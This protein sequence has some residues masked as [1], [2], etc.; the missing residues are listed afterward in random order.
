V[1]ERDER[2]LSPKI[3]SVAG[4]RFTRTADA[5]R[6]RPLPGGMTDDASAWIR[7]ARLT[8]PTSSPSRVIGMRLMR[9]RSS[10]VAISASGVS[11]AGA[12]AG[13]RHQA[14]LGLL[15]RCR[16]FV[17]GPALFALITGCSCVGA[18]RWGLQSGAR[19]AATQGR[20]I[21]ELDC[22]G[23]DA[24]QVALDGRKAVL[25]AQILELANGNFRL[26]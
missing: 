9:L 3:G 2:R 7:L 5:K 19:F 14:A 23:N 24:D 26:Y 8:M 22:R 16:K 10:R 12:V 20:K 13:H 15:A 25:A 1:L 6:Y 18:V 21:T 11:S 17:G 4:F